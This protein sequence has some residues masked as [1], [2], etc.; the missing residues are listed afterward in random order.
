MAGY[1][2]PSCGRPSPVT[3]QQRR[4]YWK[5]M[6]RLQRDAVAQ[7]GRY[8]DNKI[9]DQHVRGELLGFEQVR[10]ATGQ[11][12]Y[13]PI[14]SKSMED[15]AE[16]SAFLTEVEQYANSLGAYLDEREDGNGF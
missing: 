13:E 10:L 5:I 4:R 2:C 8:C 9:W 1:R 14:S 16:Y 12:V 15:N 11:L 3:L 7:D 6:Q